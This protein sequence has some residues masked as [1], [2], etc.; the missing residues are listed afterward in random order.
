MSAR[1]ATP[2]AGGPAAAGT[3]STDS[4]LNHA[5]GVVRGAGGRRDSP[6]VMTVPLSRRGGGARTA[7][8][9]GDGRR[10]TVHDVARAA[11]VS[12]KTVSRVVNNEPTVRPD[13]VERV[14]DA[15]ST[16]G[17][18]RNDVARNLRAGANTATIG[19][20]IEDLGNP[21][22]SLIA[23]QIEQIARTHGSLLLTSSSEEDPA[24]EQDLVLKLCQRR[25]DG[26]IVVPTNTDHS[27]C[28]TE[29]N[30]GTPMVFLDR[31][32]P[33]LSA[34]SVVID[35]YGGAKAG[36]EL[37]LTHGHHRVAII[38]HSGEIS[39]MRERVGGVRA[40]MEQGGLAV[41]ES[42]IRLGPL[43]PAQAAAAAAHL[44]D[45]PNPPTGF[46]CCNNRMTIGVID[47]LWRRGL[48]AGV[49][50]FD[51]VEFADFFPQPVNLIT[52]DIEQLARRAAEL[53]FRRIQGHRGRFQ[54]IVVPTHIVTRGRQPGHSRTPRPERSRK[55]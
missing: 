14:L 25:V 13:Y 39:T 2:V 41:D 21:F 37:L 15:V 23:R 33:G 19:L 46:F 44:L 42:L 26:L 53:L 30:M 35:N 45:T 48:A 6:T 27:F 34:D 49:V 5:S 4:A 51:D 10:P 28:L 12:I 8:K 32:P 40:A 38:G 52:Y 36:T 24:R 54:E 43:V 3:G 1:R 31:R 18:R 55:P 20:V 50:G 7:P 17:F 47:E 22:Y 9:R 16:L 11:G 29:L